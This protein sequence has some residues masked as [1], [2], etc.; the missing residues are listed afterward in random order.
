MLKNA[1]DYNRVVLWFDA[2]LFD[3]AMLCHILTCLKA[4]PHEAVELLCI[5]AFPGIEP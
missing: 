1:G 5:D 2:C 3:Q 4:L